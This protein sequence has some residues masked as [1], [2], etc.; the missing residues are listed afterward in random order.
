MKKIIINIDSRDRD[1]VKYPNSSYF[2]TKLGN[3]IR[4]V[5]SIKI[6]KIE[7]PFINIYPE[8]FNNI[9]YIK[10][11]NFFKINKN[12]IVTIIK[13][14]TNNYNQKTIIEKIN[15]QLI[16]IDLS[17]SLIDNKVEIFS[18]QSEM[19]DIDFN[20]NSEF[21]S[22]GD[23]LGFGKN[24]YNNI[25]SIISSKEILLTTDHY[26]YININNYGNIYSTDNNILNIKNYLAKISFDTNICS[27][28]IISE[29]VFDNT[30]CI[31]KFD[32]TFMNSE[33]KI[34]NTNN[35]NYSFTLILYVV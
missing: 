26:F 30:I 28:Y 1:L 9:S 12:N 32:V 31:D 27:S 35:I 5:K 18:Q 3:K 7:L 8:F 14:D 10:Y 24:I 17:I 25:T 15:S 6:D 4:N 29:H 11:N 13:I 34:M 20:N 22:L 16:L 2:S 33:Y 19:F 23:I 21:K